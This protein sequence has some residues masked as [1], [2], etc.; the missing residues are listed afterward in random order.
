MRCM[1]SE[2]IKDNRGFT[3]IEVIVSL[4]VAG[5]LGAMLVAFMGS[6][7]VR[8]SNPVINAKN[9]AYLNSI[10]ERMYSDYKYRMSYAMLNS[11][12]PEAAMGIFEGNIDTANY[13]SDASHPYS[14]AKKRISF[15]G[16]PP[17]E[18]DDSGSKI[19]KI[20]ITYQSLSATQLFTE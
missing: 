20:T 11:Q 17:Q 6:S 15:S 7:V 18:I 16:T 9:G 1:K 13:Y 14:V 19:L 5:I 8:S 2:N 10:M 3:L 12:T 4:V